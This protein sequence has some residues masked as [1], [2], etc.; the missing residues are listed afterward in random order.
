MSDMTS[1]GS[2]GPANIASNSSSERDPHATTKEQTR[3]QASDN[4]PLGEILSGDVDEIKQL[5]NE[6]TLKARTTAEQ[7][8]M[9]EKNFAARQLGG[10]A[11][12]LQN[13]GSE[14]ERSQQDAIGHYARKLGDSL[15]DLAHDMKDRDLGELAAMAEDFGRRQPV[16]FLSMAA[17]AGFAAS[18]F[19]TASAKRV[20]SDNLSS[21]TSSSS[22]DPRQG[23]YST[24]ET[25]Q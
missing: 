16:A 13:V 19:L 3:T 2:S 1:S 4:R 24:E 14:L 18:R 21:S 17:L 6:Q 12:V 8:A 5:A 15:Q 11:T 20:E 7:L 9:K 10:V 22:R 23:A 25:V